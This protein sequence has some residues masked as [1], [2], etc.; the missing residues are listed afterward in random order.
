MKTYTIEEVADILRIHAA[1]AR[2]LVREG[3]IQGVK[4]GMKWRVPEEALREYLYSRPVAENDKE[5][6]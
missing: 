6:S 5:H 3:K 4:I 1:T 2:K